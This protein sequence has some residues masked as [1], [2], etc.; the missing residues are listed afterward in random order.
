MWQLRHAGEDWFRKPGTPVYAVAKGKVILVQSRTDGNAIVIEHQLP[1]QQAWG[2]DEIYSVYL[3]V[4]SS[5]TSGESG[6]CRRLSVP[7]GSGPAIRPTYIG[8]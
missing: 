4:N 2:S 7:S 6:R 3:H 1:T 8:K 5:V